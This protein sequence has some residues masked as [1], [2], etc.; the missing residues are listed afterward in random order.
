MESSLPYAGNNDSS[1]D[2]PLPVY[3]IAK[4]TMSLRSHTWPPFCPPSTFSLFSPLPSLSGLYVTINEGGAYPTRLAHNHS[5]LLGTCS[6]YPSSI[7]GMSTRSSQRGMVRT[8]VYFLFVLSTITFPGDVVSLQVFGKVIVVLNS[9][10][11]TKD[12]LEKR[13]EVYSDRPVI[14][15]HKMYATQIGCSYLPVDVSSGWDGIGFCQQRDMVSLG[16]KG[17]RCSI[18]AWVHALRRHIFPS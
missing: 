6:I 3:L 1:R 17:A 12:L 11:A 7:L 4:P 16:V 18:G 8:N 2:S 5:P 9:V 14:P 15:F 13:G 10:K